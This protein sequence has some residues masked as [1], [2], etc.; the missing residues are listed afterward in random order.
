MR[1]QAKLCKYAKV[2]KSK[3]NCSTVFF[4]KNMKKYAKVRKSIYRIKNKNKL[5][6]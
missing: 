2:C 6:K 3:L 4:K 1:K 5:Q